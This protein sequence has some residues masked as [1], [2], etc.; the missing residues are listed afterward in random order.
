M[1]NPKCAW[2]GCSFVR[3]AKHHLQVN[4]GGVVVDVF[5]QR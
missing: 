2:P 5:C 4:E 1:K 3:F